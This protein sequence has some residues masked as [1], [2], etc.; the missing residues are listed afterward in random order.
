MAKVKQEAQPVT[1][2]TPEVPDQVKRQ[3][4]EAEAIRAQIDESM[5]KFPIRMPLPRE[6]RLP[7]PNPS[8][9]LWKDSRLSRRVKLLPHLRLRRANR[10]GSSATAHSP[11]GWSRRRKSNQA[12]A[13]RL[14]QLEQL[15]TSMKVRGAEEVRPDAAGRRPS[16][17][18][19]TEEEA[20][21][22]AT[23]S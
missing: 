2:Y 20:R 11:G 21:T 9:V 17:K 18:L 5:G 22:T 3:M 13:E 10:A 1:D 7:S 23:S 16:R 6:R 8:P 19:V 15:I 4:A 14:G 12:L